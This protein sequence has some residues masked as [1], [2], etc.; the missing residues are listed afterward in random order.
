MILKSLTG[1]AITIPLEDSTEWTIEV[2]GT[3]VP[4]DVGE[5]LL[6]KAP[7]QLEKAG[8]TEG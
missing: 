2:E 4:D 8:E 5:K 1:Q 6:Q 3:E 7:E